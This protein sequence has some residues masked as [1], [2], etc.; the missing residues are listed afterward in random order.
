MSCFLLNNGNGFISDASI[1]KIIIIR[2]DADVLFNCLI[3]IYNNKITKVVVMS[4]LKIKHL[5]NVIVAVILGLLSSII[6]VT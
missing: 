3:C 1:K 2:L 5:R 4:Y 6:L